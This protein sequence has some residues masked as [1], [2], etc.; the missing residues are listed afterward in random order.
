M[1]NKI[2]GGIGIIEDLTEDYKN[3][4]KIQELLRIDNL[5]KLNNRATFDSYILSH[6]PALN[7]P[8][9]IITFDINT[10][11]VINTSFGYEMGNNVLIKIGETLLDYAKNNANIDAF[12]IG[13][14]EFALILTNTEINEADDIGKEIK[15]IISKLDDFNF[16]INISYGVDETDNFDKSLSETYNQSLVDLNSNKI[17]DGSSI[18][19]KTID[20]IMTTLFEKNKRERMHSERVSYISKK[21]AEKFNL[22]TAFTNRVELAGRLH[23]IGKINISEEIL[24]K[25]GKLTDREWKSIKKHPES[26]FKILSSVPE[27]LDIAN[28]V[29]TH[30]ER[31]DGK[32]Y[33][34]GISGHNIPL[35]AR[36]ICVADAYDAMIEERPYRLS[37]TEDQAIKELIDNKGTQ[38]DPEVVDKF[39]TI[40]SNNEL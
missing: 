7:Y 24:D 17:Y 22:G 31:Y 10:F 13:G 8:I 32:G 4:E 6:Q 15:N 40:T 21:I 18:S 25:P 39:I 1:D 9:S 20:L 26:G 38:F 33:P 16:V 37:L 5:T 12:R 11:Q 19:I 3:K 36:I 27:Y 14:D 2:S 34:R 30:H 35:E 23:D 28:I 29:L